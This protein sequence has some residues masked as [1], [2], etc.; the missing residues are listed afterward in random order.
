MKNTLIHS[1]L[2]WFTLTVFAFNVFAEEA[3]PKVPRGKIERITNFNSKY[4]N[5]R[6]IDVWLPD[7]YDKTKTYAVLYMHDGQMLFDADQTWNKQAWNIAQTADS[8]M[9]AKLVRE[10]IVVGI[11]NDKQTRH[12]DFFPQKPF[13]YLTKSRKAWVTGT[14]Y[15]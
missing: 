1:T 15:C 11:W 8:L 10:F 4:T 7:S 9:K 3:L 14:A 6:N 5:S 12:A 2:F 13:N